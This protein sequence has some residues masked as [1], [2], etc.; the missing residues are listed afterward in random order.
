MGLRAQ[1]KEMLENHERYA[2]SLQG[3]GLLRLHIRDDLRLHIWNH[4]YAYPGASPIHDH[5]QWHL[6]SFVVAGHIENTRYVEVDARDP[7]GFLF[8]K[9]TIQAGYGCH[10]TDEEQRCYLKKLPAELYNPGDSYQQQNTEI[11]WTKAAPGTVTLM[12]KIPATDGK[13][14][15]IFWPYGTEWG[16][17]EPRVAMVREVEEILGQCL[18]EHFK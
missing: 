9:R 3:L 10:F 11:H 5:L 17:A 15:R 16:T 4:E 6:S 13:A 12:H 8:N 2:W 1:I 18:Q 14:A 7:A